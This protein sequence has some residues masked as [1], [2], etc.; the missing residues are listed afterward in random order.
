MRRLI[1]LLV[2]VACGSKQ[3]SSLPAED[4]KRALTAAQQC[5]ETV[6]SLAPTYQMVG[7]KLTAALKLDRTE[8]TR[9]M[10][11][12]IELLISTREMLCSI[13]QATVQDVLGMAPRDEEIVAAAGRVKA[14]VDRLGAARKAY[15]ELLGAAS[16]AQAPVDQDALVERFSHALL[17]Q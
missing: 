7:P 9:L 12:S 16:A 14:A 2:L 17:G 6:D 11:N 5:T 4:R 15:D 8:A 13:S 3:P 10:R 1:A